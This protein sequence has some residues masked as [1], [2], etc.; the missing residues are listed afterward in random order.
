MVDSLVLRL[1]GERWQVDLGRYAD[2]E[3]HVTRLRELWSRV[4]DDS[5]GEVDVVFRP[6][7]DEAQSTLT[8]CLPDRTDGS[9]PYSFSRAVTQAAIDRLAGTALLLHAAGLV[10]DDARRGVVL[11][12]SSGTGKSTAARRLGQ[13]LGYLSDELMLV[14]ERE[15]LHGLTKPISLIVPEFPGGKDESSPDEL[16]L[17][18]TPAMP[19]RLAALVCLARTQE[20]VPPR[21]DLISVHELIAEVVPQ[22]SSLWR[23]DRPLRRLADAALRGGGPFRLSYAEIVDAEPLV[24]GLLEAEP[25]PDGVRDWIEHGPSE[26]ERWQERAGAT[27]AVGDLD[28]DALISRAPWTDAI[29]QDGEV[30]VLVGPAF[31]RIAGIAASIWLA[32]AR[33]LTVAELSDELAREHGPHPEADALVQAALREL[34][35][36]ELIDVVSIGGAS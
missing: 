19:P 29:E 12:A 23:V 18:P 35:Q 3:G 6:D 4:V 8:P 32:C 9:F 25:M 16:G 13:R 30:S 27:T 2:P 17:G 1:F 22:T 5:A 24:R 26:D 10:S 20:A 14:D 11:V 36:R 28:D 31:T 33:P 7:P 34:G 15:E 21:L